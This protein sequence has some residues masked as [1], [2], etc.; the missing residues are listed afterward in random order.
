MARRSPVGTCVVVESAVV[1]A[2]MNVIAVME[3]SDVQVP[4]IA[5]VSSTTSPVHTIIDSP[6]KYIHGGPKSGTIFVRLNFTKY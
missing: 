6:R 3:S 1:Q 2:E 4:V 5:A